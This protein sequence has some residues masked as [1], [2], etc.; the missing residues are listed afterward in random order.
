M[1]YEVQTYKNGKW[2][3]SSVQDDMDEGIY[4]AQRLLQNKRNSAVRVV[5]EIFNED[6]DTYRMKVVFRR[7]RKGSEESSSE[8]AKGDGE[9]TKKKRVKPKDIPLMTRM[10]TAINKGVTAFIHSTV[11]LI[12]KFAVIIGLGV[13]L[14]VTMN[15][16][17]DKL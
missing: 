13:W 17:A 15:D 10:V 4:E 9:R 6:N 1:N 11:F 8:G 3:I 14:L 16:L 2:I 7:S 12:L 5:Q